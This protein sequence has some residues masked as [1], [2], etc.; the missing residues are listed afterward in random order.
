M[1]IATGA[2]VSLEKNSIPWDPNPDSNGAV[3]VLPLMDVK[4]E[5]RLAVKG[6]KDGDRKSAV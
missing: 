6:K 4:Q 1:H 5:T 2:S 3:R